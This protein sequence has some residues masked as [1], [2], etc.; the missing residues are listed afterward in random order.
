MP[1]AASKPQSPQQ[2]SAQHSPCPPN[3]WPGRPHL[4]V[5]Q[6]CIS[7]PWPALTAWQG[8]SG[9]AV[10][11][12]PRRPFST[13]AATCTHSRRW[14]YCRTQPTDTL[15]LDCPPGAAQREAMAETQFRLPLLSCRTNSGRGCRFELTLQTPA[16][17]PAKTHTRGDTAN[18]SRPMMLHTVHH[19]ESRLNPRSAVVRLPHFEQFRSYLLAHS[20]VD[21]PTELF[22]YRFL[23]ST[24]ARRL[25]GLRTASLRAGLHR[26]STTLK[27]SCDVVEIQVGR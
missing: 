27:P 12:W 2:A 10:P 15:D 9:E 24:E 11:R 1:T 26:I 18:S 23:P 20:Y 3:P 8:R 7:L 13:P 14:R 19:I 4:P 17:M 21:L 25:N 6:P 5:D 22:P 16:P